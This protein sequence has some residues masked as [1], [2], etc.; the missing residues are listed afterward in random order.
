MFFLCCKFYKFFFEYFKFHIKKLLL[1]FQTA[2]L[3]LHPPRKFFFSRSSV[4]RCSSKALRSSSSVIPHMPPYPYTHAANNTN[5]LIIQ[6]FVPDYYRR[7]VLMFIER[8]FDFVHKTLLFSFPVCAPPSLFREFPVNSS[9]LRNASFASLFK[10][11]GV[12]TISV[13]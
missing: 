9:N 4:R 3:I 5:R 1:L 8:F 13:T 10:P 6:Y 11:V 12:L 2:I 7:F